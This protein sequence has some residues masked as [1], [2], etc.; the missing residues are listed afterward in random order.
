MKAKLRLKEKAFELRKQGLSYSEINKRVPVSKST[1]SLWL[2]D[3][4]LTTKQK[5]R[6]KELSKTGQPY[7]ARAQKKIRVERTK[8][9]IGN[10]K[11]EVSVITDRELLY[12]GTVLYWAEGAKQKKH[13]PSERVSFSNSDPAMIRVFLKWLTNVAK[14][15]GD[16]IDFQIYS[17]ENIRD[18]EREIVKYWSAITGYPEDKFDKIYYKKDKK[19][20][21]RR[22]QGKNYYGLLRV[23]VKK[24]TDLNRKIAGW[25]EGVCI[26][27]GMV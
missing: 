6:L 8:V 12:I 1:L 17:N 7:G 24:S 21:Y 15:D 4:Q 22:N 3:V 10:A 14:V 27:C 9:I 23:V 19:K 16:L 2:R 11:K 20:K 18:R 5:F 26:H 25:I 13:N